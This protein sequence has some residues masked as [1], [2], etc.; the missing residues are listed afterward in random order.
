MKDCVEEGFSAELKDHLASEGFFVSTTVGMSMYPMLRNR[1]DRVVILPVGEGRLRR[2]DLPLYLRE[3]GQYILHRVIAVKEDHYV[4]RGDNTWSK[5]YVRDEQILGVVSEFYRGKKH[6]RTDA[7]LYRLY[8]AFWHTIY[9]LRRW[10]L[11]VRKFAAR[12]KRGRIRDVQ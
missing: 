2:W 9:P 5:E 7:R 3:D 11:G 1:R 8:A 10:W 4:I 6:I 12:I